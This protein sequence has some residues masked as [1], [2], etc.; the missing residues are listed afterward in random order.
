MPDLS[1]RV[2]F[3]GH[4]AAVEDLA[5][6]DEITVEQGE[7]AAWEAR[8]VMA[9]C[10]DDQGN[11]ARQK[12]LNLRARTQVRVELQIGSAGFKP[13]IEGPIV[14]M[15]NVM[16]SR[17]GRSTMTITVHDDS[18]WLNLKSGPVSV[19]DKT[20]AVI[21]RQLFLDESEGHIASTQIVFPP[22]ITPP[23]LGSNFS[24]LGTAMQMLRSLAQRNGVH[25]FVLPGPTAGASIGCLK[26]DPEDPSSLPPLILL[27]ANRNL[28]EVNATEDPES[29]SQTVAHTLRFSD[30][31]VVSYTSQQ[32][33]ESLLGSAPAAPTPPPRTASPS[34]S[35]RE[36]ASAIA[37]AHARLKNFPVKYTGRLIPGCYSALLQP[38]QKVALNAGAARDS[39][40]LLL[41]KV[42][43][44]ITPSIYDVNFEGR[45]NSIATLQAASPGLPA[46]IL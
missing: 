26:G 14:S 3:G 17:P 36:D 44:R 5:A 22:D 34:A 45:G 29:S 25:L 41:T 13:L 7:G 28:A 30:Q 31:Q 40:I 33:D 23:S 42:T 37:R 1:F 24:E 2:Y 10:L 21:A 19:A 8:I 4:A 20:D 15:H 6:I 16:D 11:W 35:T 27:G 39:A 46:G 43:H 38:F 18:A 12:E 32:S 9:L